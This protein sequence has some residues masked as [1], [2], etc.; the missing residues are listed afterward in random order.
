MQYQLVIDNKNII[1]VSNE[2]KETVINNFGKIDSTT[3]DNIT[4]LKLNN[5]DD[6]MINELMNFLPYLHSLNKAELVNLET[7]KIIT[8]LNKLY[9]KN[10]ELI[11][12]DNY[13]QNDL[14]SK[15][16]RLNKDVLNSIIYKLKKDFKALTTIDIKGLIAVNAMANIQKELKSVFVDTKIENYN[17]KLAVQGRENILK[18]LIYNNNNKSPKIMDYYKLKNNSPKE[19]S[20]K[21]EFK[22]LV[23]IDNESE[24]KN[25]KMK[26]TYEDIID[27]TEPEAKLLIKDREMFLQL[28][29][30][31]KE[32]LYSSIFFQ[33]M[34]NNLIDQ[35]KGVKGKLKLEVQ[36]V[37][38]DHISQI[39]DYKDEFH[40]I[41]NISEMVVTTDDNKLHDSL[42]HLIKNNKLNVISIFSQSIL[43]NCDE[44]LNAIIHNITNSNNIDKTIII[45]LVLPDN[46]DTKYIDEIHSLALE[47]SKISFYKG[48]KYI[49]EEVSDTEDEFI[50]EI[51]SIFEAEQETYS[52]KEEV[53]LLSDNEFIIDLTV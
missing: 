33:G 53:P 2:K 20:K 25:K 19:I 51:E 39:A 47:N 1:L 42:I 21:R 41:K 31:K 14:L 11:S 9:T 26:Q 32:T 18:E 38:N 5:I 10:L 46:Y 50:K 6:S 30:Q 13:S 28:D 15:E 45:E 7:K 29:V 17:I 43:S 49:N 52:N 35:A 3:R 22:D 12:I 37:T 44:L 8:A 36:H 34:V 16:D 24:V 4:S 40:N 23:T 48:I 27:L